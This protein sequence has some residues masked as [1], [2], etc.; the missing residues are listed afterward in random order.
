VNHR[1]APESTASHDPAR[2][3]SAAAIYEANAVYWS[4]QRGIDAERC[5]DFQLELARE[6]RERAA[7]L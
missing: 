2:L 7:A 1:T 4:T 5:R 6:L 3:L